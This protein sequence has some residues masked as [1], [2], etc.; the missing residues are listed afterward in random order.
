MDLNKMYFDSF[1]NKL[2]ILQLVNAEPEWAANRIQIGENAIISLDEA[3]VRITDLEQQLAAM[4][5]AKESEYEAGGNTAMELEKER[6]LR[7]RLEE[8]LRVE[9]GYFWERWKHRAH[10][11]DGM[12]ILSEEHSDGGIE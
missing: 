6:Y 5:A 10:D 9:F 7:R 2:N 4:T 3:Q 11:D 8:Q 1:G 12:Q